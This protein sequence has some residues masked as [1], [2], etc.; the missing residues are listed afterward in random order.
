MILTATLM[1]VQFGLA[2]YARQV[3]AGAAQDGAANGA[4]RDSTPEQG[5]IL[6]EHLVDQAGSSLL[7][8][9]RAEVTI[10]ADRVVVTVRGEVVSLIPFRGSIPVEASGSA[11][12]EA[13]RPQLVGS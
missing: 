11:P 10:D 4:R 12:I 3:L 13:F 5:R 7:T 1:V 8:S 6:T 2:Y 9:Y